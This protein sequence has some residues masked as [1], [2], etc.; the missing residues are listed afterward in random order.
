MDT[1]VLLVIVMAICGFATFLACAASDSADNPDAL[2][3]AQTEKGM[4]LVE[5][6]AKRRSVRS[7]KAG[8]LPPEQ[9]AQLCWAA[10]GITDKRRGLRAAPSAGALYPLE[11]YIVTADGVD[12]YTPADHALRR[13]AAG[14]VRP[15]LARAAL[16]Q[17]CVASA[18]ATFVLTGV[19]ERTAAKYGRRAGRYV[20]ME[21]GHAA[22]NI[23]LQAVALEL[24]AVPVGAFDDGAVAMALSLPAKHAPMYLIPVGTP[25]D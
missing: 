11:L 24:G 8:A 22:Q 4:P 17:S 19:V 21:V 2:P 9:I 10:Q 25:R 23:L 13:H 6:I 3:A 15:A 1:L 18:P 20:W 16:G 5:A 14:D 7:F 12:H